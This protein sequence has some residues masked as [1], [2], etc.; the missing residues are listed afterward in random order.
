MSTR[1]LSKKELIKKIATEVEDPKLREQL[2]DALL[3]Q[4]KS[5][6]NGWE[7][8][9]HMA[10]H[11]DAVP[12]NVRLY[13]WVNAIVGV[14][15]FSIILT[16][17][18]GTPKTDTSYSFLQFMLFFVPLLALLQHN[19]LCNV[20]KWQRRGRKPPRKFW[21]AMIQPPADEK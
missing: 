20:S 3:E 12:S 6:I 21:G 17:L 14:V 16:Y 11:P 5:R 9:P 19:K 15:F 10:V 7:S 4:E 18:K 13:K 8:Q 2:I 1:E